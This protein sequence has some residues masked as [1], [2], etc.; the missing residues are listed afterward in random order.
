MLILRVI[1]TV[2]GVARENKQNKSST[3]RS[4]IQVT[5]SL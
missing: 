2:F 4:Q 5:L 3:T 1:T